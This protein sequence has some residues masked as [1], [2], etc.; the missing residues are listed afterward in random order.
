MRVIYQN[1][2]RTHPGPTQV[3]LDLKYDLETL[4]RGA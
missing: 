2:V 4:R 1:S 3:D